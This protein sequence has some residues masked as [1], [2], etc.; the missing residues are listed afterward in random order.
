MNKGENSK[1]NQPEIQEKARWQRDGRKSLGIVAAQRNRKTRF[2]SSQFSGQHRISLQFSG[3]HRQ[4]RTHPGNASSSRSYLTCTKVYRQLGKK[5]PDSSPRSIRY[6]HPIRAS[7]PSFSLPRCRR[8][9]RASSWVNRERERRAIKQPRRRAS[10]IHNRAVGKSCVLMP[11]MSR[12]RDIPR[13][14]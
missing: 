8:G 12:Q 10:S 14:L 4:R 9:R 2:A 6:I 11:E 5:Q 13:S 1:G 3:V 7:S